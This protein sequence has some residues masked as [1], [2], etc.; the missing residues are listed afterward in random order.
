MT[1]ADHHGTTLTM[2]RVLICPNCDEPSFTVWQKQVLGPG[3][4]KRC[5]RCGAF[6]S[7]SRIHFVPILVL[8]AA[9]PIVLILTSLQH[10]VVAGVAAAILLLLASALYQH[11]FVPLVVRSKPP[12]E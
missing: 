4:K 8:T 7:V 2:K 11:Y 6:V 9:F 10:G 3:R 1:A 12:S 5:R